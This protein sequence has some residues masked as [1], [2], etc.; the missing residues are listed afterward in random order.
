M[1]KFA[2]YDTLEEL[3]A[4]RARE[5]KISSEKKDLTNSEITLRPINWEQ[6]LQRETAAAQTITDLKEIYADRR[7][8]HF[9]DPGAEKESRLQRLLY[10]DRYLAEEEIGTISPVFQVYKG[11]FPELNSSKKN[12]LEKI[13][14][15]DIFLFYPQEAYQCAKLRGIPLTE[16]EIKYGQ[17]TRS[18]LLVV[19]KKDHLHLLEEP[20]LADDGLYVL[21]HRCQHEEERVS[22]SRLGEGGLGE[23]FKYVN[24]F[25]E[26]IK[27]DQQGDL[28]SQP[29]CRVVKKI[30]P[31]HVDTDLEVLIRKSFYI[32]DKMARQ[33]DPRLNNLAGSRFVNKRKEMV[34]SDL[35]DQTFT[36]FFEQIRTEYKGSFDA[37]FYATIDQL[38]RLQGAL[39]VSGIAHSDIKAENIM[40]KVGEQAPSFE[41]LE[42]PQELPDLIWNYLQKEPIYTKNCL[43]LFDFGIS[44]LVSETKHTEISPSINFTPGSIDEDFINN[45]F[46]PNYSTDTYAFG[47][48]LRNI[49]K[50]ELT[51]Y[52]TRPD[53]LFVSAEQKAIRDQINKLDPDYK[54]FVRT[55]F[56]KDI[57]KSIGPSKSKLAV[58]RDMKKSVENLDKYNRQWISLFE[59]AI[60]ERMV[61]VDDRVPQLI[62]YFT[63]SPYDRFINNKL[64]TS[65]VIR[66]LE[67]KIGEILK[68]YR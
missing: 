39:M 59:K 34:V 65:L 33:I 21:W 24:I 26:D 42:K 8:V 4:A 22:L 11:K 10:P 48:I 28:I 46:Y 36:S 31:E 56:L 40:G 47:I 18:A 16:M 49:F 55:T 38:L 60:S 19:S 29:R 6:E 15:E 45:G 32:E 9:F 52:F 66:Q 13:K 27:Q 1:V 41:G 25:E 54:Y 64:T 17:E 50:E 61:D 14:M 58:V 44:R 35:L 51:R 67:D 30:L 53:T 5:L 62:Y 63:C 68:N 7:L 2:G 23:V 43:K 57:E 12:L 37:A 3:I 20:L